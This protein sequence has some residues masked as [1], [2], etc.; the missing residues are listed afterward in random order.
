MLDYSHYI[1]RGQ[2]DSEWR[3][4]TSLD[5]ELKRKRKDKRNTLAKEHLENFKYAVRGRRG[6]NPQ[7]LQDENDWWALGQH[8]GLSTPLLDW[9]ESPFV[10]LYFAMEKSTKTSKGKRAVYALGNSRVANSKITKSWTSSE[11]P[12]I[13]ERIKPLQDENDRLVSQSGLF[14]RTPLGVTVED[15]VDQN[16]KG[17]TSGALIKLIVPEKGRLDCLRTLNKMNINHLTLFPDLYGSS[18]HCNKQLEIDKY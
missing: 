5:R 1:W 9:T 2:R 6:K 17:A 14:T 15:W 8:T 13:L 7:E 10:A 4:E 12:P 16:R 11:R 18:G 3:L